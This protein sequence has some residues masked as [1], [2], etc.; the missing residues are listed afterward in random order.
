MRIAIDARESGTTSGRYVDKLI[1]HIYKIDTDHEFVIMTKP[2]RLDYMR[3]IAP[4]FKAVTADYKEFTFAEQLSFLQFCRKTKAD[5]I[6]FP[7]VHQPILYTGKKI[8]T[9]NDLTTLRFRNPAKN[10]VT[11]WLKQRAYG[12]VNR[13]AAYSSVH[14]LTFTEFVKKDFINYTGVS[15]KKITSVPLAAEEITEDEQAITSLT[16]KQ[17]IMY[18]GRPLPHKNLGRLIESFKLLQQK[19]P[20]LRLVLVGKTDKLY[21]KHREYVE[22]QNIK[23][24]VFTGFVSD[25]ELRWLYKN[26]R[27]YVFPSLSEGFGLPGLEAMI[28]GAPVVSSDTTCLPEVHGRAAHYFDPLSIDDMASKIAEVLE[29][30]KLRGELI[31]KGSTHA[32]K[33]SWDKT[34]RETLSIYDQVLS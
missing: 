20:E 28:H 13:V 15:D 4:N 30:N 31:E 19:H 8:T 14:L 29:N 11:F 34:A 10:P 12:L 22:Q 21:Q 5:L 16:R 2:K 33:Y 7:M 3:Q 24:V 6:H 25:G 23:N 17:F 9:I 32:R 18:I 26:C 27:A 1:E